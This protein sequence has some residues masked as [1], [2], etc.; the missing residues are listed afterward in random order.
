MGFGVIL[1]YMNEFHRD[2]LKLRYLF[3]STMA[4]YDRPGILNIQP[5]VYAFYFF[6]YGILQWIIIGH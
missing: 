3:G 6:T 5:N 2:K 1:M 4:I